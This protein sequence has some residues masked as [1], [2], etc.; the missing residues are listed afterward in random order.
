MN[1]NYEI[2]TEQ[3]DQLE[4]FAAKYEQLKNMIDL[5][6]WHILEETSSDHSGVKRIKSLSSALVELADKRNEELELLIKEIERK[7]EKDV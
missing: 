4:E 7:G 2:T 5:L 3:M 6:N 1:E